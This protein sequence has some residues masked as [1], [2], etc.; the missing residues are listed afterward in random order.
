MRQCALENGVEQAKTLDH[1]LLVNQLY[2]MHCEPKIDPGKP[3]FVTDYPTAISPLTRSQPD[4]PHLSE[5]WELLIGGLEIGT[6]YTELNDPEQ[7]RARF[8]QQLAGSDEEEQ[9]FRTLDEDFIHSLRVGMPPAGGLGLGIDRIV[10]LLTNNQSIRDVILFPLLK[11]ES[12][13][14][15]PD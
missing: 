15:E 5:R 1:W 13:G 7:Q 6:A 9:A 4:R 14:S 8:T 12:A 2:E 3:T 10:M 11:P